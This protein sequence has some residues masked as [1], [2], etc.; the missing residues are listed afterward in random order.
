MLVVRAGE[1]RDCGLEPAAGLPS[2][3]GC[4]DGVWTARGGITALQDADQQLDRVFLHSRGVS[5]FEVPPRWEGDRGSA[6]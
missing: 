4:R 6:G 1:P 5:G 3:A 2:D